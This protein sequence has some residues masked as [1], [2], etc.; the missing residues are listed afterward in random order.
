MRP[1]LLFLLFFSYKGYSQ[2]KTYTLSDNGDT[3]NCID[4]KN[5]KQGKWVVHHDELRG[6]PG[7]EEEGLFKDD[8]KEGAWRL[9]TLTGDLIG[10]E[11]YRWGNKDG[12]NRYF[13]KTGELVRE[14]SWKALNP[15][16]QY[17]TLEVEDIDHLDHY[18]TVVVKNEGVGLKHG[19]WKYYDPSTGMIY[20]TETYTLGKLETPKVSEK[21]VALSDST[22]TPAKPKEV[23]DFE[24]KN[25][26]KKKVKYVDGSVNY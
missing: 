16:K 25:K 1:I 20:K 12:I 22:K 10:I 23:R 6:E 26:G 15:D 18:K 9:Y 14:E 13:S 21:T 2:C 3:L 5:L 7:F 19:E 11:Q 4:H 8:R 17:D 24:K